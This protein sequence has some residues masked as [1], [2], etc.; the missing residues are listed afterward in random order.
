MNRVMPC[1]QCGSSIQTRILLP[2]DLPAW[3]RNQND[4]Q[5][6]LVYKDDRIISIICPACRSSCQITLEGF[7]LMLP[8]GRQFKQA[9]ARIRTLPKRQIE[10]NGRRALVSRFESINDNATFDVVSDYETYQTLQVYGGE[11]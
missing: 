1:E 8:E 5:T 11:R 7:A 9:H 3:L 6:W 2:E 4:M 10:V